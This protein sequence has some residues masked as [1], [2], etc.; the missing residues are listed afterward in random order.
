VR[1]VAFLIAASPN[2]AFYSQIAALN[3]RMRSLTWTG[4]RPSLHVFVGGDTQADTIAAWRPYLGD[5]QIIWTSKERFVREGDWAQSDDVFRGAPEADVLIALDADTFP[6]TGFES[7]LDRVHETGAVAGVIAHYPTVLDF[8]FDT[9]SNT[10]SVRSGPGRTS[11][12]E[13]WGRLADGVTVIPLDFA[14]LHSLLGPEHPTDQRLTPFYL[15]FGVVAFPKAAFDAVA[16]R[17]LDMRQRLLSRLPHPDFSGQVALTL[18]IADARVRTWA[19]PMRYNFPNDANA[20]RLHPEE[21]RNVAIVHYL[22]TAEFDR[23]RIFAS[24]DA[25]AAFL[26]QPLSGVNRVFREA[27]VATLDVRYP[28]PRDDGQARPRQT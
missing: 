2:D 15:N 28:F 4:W 11:L 18:A 10:F 12:R 26:A 19:L 1:R 3:A 9:A 24:A 25:Y 8:E 21:L 6:V 7:M 16:P 17:Y 27:V 20:E 14:Y 23:H 22:R 13:A 5:V